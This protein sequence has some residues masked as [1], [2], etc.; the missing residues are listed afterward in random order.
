MN[1]NISNPILSQSEVKYDRCLSLYR[2][3]S[4][5]FQVCAFVENHRYTNKVL[6]ALKKF[7]DFALLQ[8]ELSPNA[9]LSL[10]IAESKHML[11]EL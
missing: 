1:V 7:L 2:L 10:L 11:D 5:F 8:Y 9:S 4:I 6:L 3:T